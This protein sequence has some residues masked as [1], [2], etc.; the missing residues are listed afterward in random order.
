MKLQKSDPRRE[1]EEEAKTKRSQDISLGNHDSLVLLPTKTN[2][3]RK[4]PVSQSQPNSF[5]HKRH[6]SHPNIASK[7]LEGLEIYRT[8]RQNEPRLAGKKRENEQR[9]KQ[10]E[11]FRK[12]DIDPE[13]EIDIS[14]DSISKGLEYAKG[15]EQ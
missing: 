13:K 6:D 2:S 10:E 12:I 1:I 9:R 3:E 14:L 11:M 8:E 15:S 7:G 5:S 4:M